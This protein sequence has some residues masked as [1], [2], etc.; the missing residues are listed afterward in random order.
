MSKYKKR[1]DKKLQDYFSPLINQQFT[2]EVNKRMNIL[3]KEFVSNGGKRIRPIF[4]IMTYLSK[5]NI[6][7]LDDVIKVSLSLELLHNGTL[8]HDDIMD[9]SELRRGK[10]AYHIAFQKWYDSKYKREYD[11]FGVAMGILGGDALMTLGLLQILNSSFSEKIKNRL[12]EIYARSFVELIEGQA[13]DMEIAFRKTNLEEYYEMISGKT[14]SL[15]RA[16]AEMGCTMCESDDSFKNNFVKFMNCIGY[17]FQIQDDILGT[18]GSVEKFGKPVDSD[19]KEGKSTI[20]TI[21]A[22]QKANEE[23][24]KILNNVLGKEDASD[25]EVDNVRKVFIE[26]GAKKYAEEVAQDWINKA[27]IYLE[28][29]NLKGEPKDFFEGIVNYIINRDI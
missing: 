22:Y 14:A 1:I 13:L 28:K 27:K 12:C 24:I 8:V 5:G 10:P 19:I 29:L 20:L 17:A 18:F 23:Q 2:G 6:D 25:E 15:F 21:Y 4:A 3:I 11:N 16:C 26:T 7:K 9:K